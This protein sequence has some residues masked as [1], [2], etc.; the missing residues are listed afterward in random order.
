MFTFNEDGSHDCVPVMWAYGIPCPA[1]V[2]PNASPHKED[3][4]LHPDDHLI[5]CSK[6]DSG[7]HTS[8]FKLFF[9]NV[10]SVNFNEGYVFW[11]LS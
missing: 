2:S 11:L 8:H 1:M 3:K 5:W 10:K 4:L 6:V 9:E 7:P